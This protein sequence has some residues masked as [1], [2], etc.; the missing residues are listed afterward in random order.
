MK[1]PMLTTVLGYLLVTLAGTLGSTGVS[2]NAASDCRQEAK[3]YD[4]SPEQLDDYING[5][6]ASRGEYIAEDVNEMDYV[7]PDESL[8]QE[9]E[10]QES[11]DVNEMDYVSPDES[12]DQEEE[13]QESVTDEGDVT[14]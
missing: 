2:A 7:P 4:V 12:L 10:P 8:D 14:Y 1:Q 9:E 13:P 6:M 11:V 5:C 3:D